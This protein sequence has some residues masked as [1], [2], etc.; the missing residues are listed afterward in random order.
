MCALFCLFTFFFGPYESHGGV[1]CACVWCVYVPFTLFGRSVGHPFSNLSIRLC[2]QIEAAATTTISTSQC[3]YSG[4]CVIWKS[5]SILHVWM[6]SPCAPHIAMVCVL[7]HT[8]THTH[9]FFPSLYPVVVSECLRQES[10]LSHPN[11]YVRVCV[12][13]L[14]AH[15]W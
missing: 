5:H 4:E 13:V 15:K 12:S 11:V 3:E 7:R 10:T 8:H 6:S 1:W 9:S 2:V 14:R